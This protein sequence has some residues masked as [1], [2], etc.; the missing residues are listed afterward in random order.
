MTKIL[1]CAL[2]FALASQ[3]VVDVV[4]PEPF[5]VG[6]EAIASQMQLADENRPSRPPLVQL[7]DENRPSRPPLAQFARENGVSFVASA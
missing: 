2:G 4:G 6:T 3:A 1:A 7:A 5:A